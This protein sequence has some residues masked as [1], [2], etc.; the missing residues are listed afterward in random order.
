MSLQV[1]NERAAKGEQLALGKWSPYVEGLSGVDAAFTALIME[2]TAKWMGNMEETVRATNVGNFDRFAFPLIRAVYP[3]LVAQDLVSVQP[4]DGPVGMIFY[5]DMIYGS[6]KGS[7]TQG[8]PVFSSLTGHPGD[9][10]FSSPEISDEALTDGAG[11]AAVTGTLS[12]TPVVPGTLQITDGTQT[13]TD[14]GAGN[15]QGTVNPAGVNTVNYSTGLVTLTFAGVVAAGTS[16]TASY[17]YDN[18]ANQMVPEID[19]QLISTPVQAKVFKLRTRYSL[20]AA[21]NLRA[22]HGLSAET[23][24]VSALAQV[25]RFEIDRTII[26]EINSFA[27]AR[28]I[29]WS[30]SPPAGISW[31]EHKLSFVDALIRGS[32]NIF[33]LTRRGQPN[34]VVTGMAG[35]NVVESIPGFKP[36]PQLSTPNGVVFAGVLGSRWRVYKDPY[37]IDG[38]NTQK[39]FLIGYKG[40]SFLEAGFVYA[41][42]IPFYTTP[43]ITLDDFVVRKGMAT[44]WGRKKINGRFYCSGT[45]TGTWSP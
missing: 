34:W 40:P 9:S 38:D 11:A 24:L 23:E 14:D 31:T 43:S 26:R 19:F 4:M 32:N 44:S 10:T 42:Y 5:F 13:V 21:Q 35:S 29:T 45:I 27:A 7:I 33:E 25:L 20:E 8:Q 16:V 41:P 12:Y 22:L 3:N 17:E 37:N 15:L 30:Q 2:N 28:A 6:T 18:E 36:S 39:N 1:L